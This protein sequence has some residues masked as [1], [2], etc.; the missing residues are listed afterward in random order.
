MTA[1]LRYD[2][3]RQAVAEAKTFDE[4]REWE[5]KAAA[6]REYTRRIGDRDMELDAL[7]I[8]SLAHR[9]RGQLLAELKRKGTLVEGRKKLS[10]ADD[11]SERVTLEELKVTPNES[12]RDQKVAALDGNSFDRLLKRCRQYAKDHPEKHTFDV[13]RPPDEPLAGARAIMG[14]RQE[15]DDSLDYFPTPPWATRALFEYAFKPLQPNGEYLGSSIWEPACGEGHMAEVLSEYSK[16]VFASDVHDYGYGAVQDFLGGAWAIP[17]A[18]WIIT[19][20][21]FGDKTEQF[22]LRALDLARVGVAMFVRLQWLETIGRYEKIFRDQPPTQICF[23]AERVNLCKGEWK[24]DGST[25]TAYIWLVWIKHKKPL[26]PFWIPPGRQ[27]ELTRA[28]DVE[29]FTARPV[30]KKHHNVGL[31]N[32]GEG[33][34]SSF[35]SRMIQTN[36]SS[37]WQWSDECQPSSTAPTQG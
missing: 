3:A 9:R 29:R 19:N 18:D 1:L 14:S 27:K 15:P 11:G 13:L 37:L 28:D 32:E 26:A 25:A 33:A 2:I 8:R 34:I 23:F 5:D 7:E 30:V 21:P 16:D 36:K 35:A 10:A 31:A 4:V 20:P 22:V 17:L 12:S 6:V 24:P